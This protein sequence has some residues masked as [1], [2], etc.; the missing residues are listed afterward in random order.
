MSP[1]YRWSADKGEPIPVETDE[2]RLER[3][4]RELRE[5][6]QREWELAE[7]ERERKR[8]GSYL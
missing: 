1:R 6:K 8:V 2:E 4:E 5:L 7:E 3:E